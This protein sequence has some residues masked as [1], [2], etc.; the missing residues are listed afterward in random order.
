MSGARDLVRNPARPARDRLRSLL[1]VASVATALLGGC[2]GGGGDNSS[3]ST[4]TPTPAPVVVALPNTL[5]VTI[6]AGPAALA[7]ANEAAANALFATVT[8]CAP[9]STTACRSIDHIQVDTGSTG[10]RIIASA[11]GAAAPA[12]SIDPTTGFAT[13][14]C[15]QFADGYSW[16]T[17]ATADVTLGGRTVASLPVHV[18]G[19]PAAGS[20]PASCASGPSENTVVAFGA[21]GVLGLGNYVQDCGPACATRAVSAFYY[22]CPTSSATSCTPTT[23]SLARQVTNPVALLGTD[24]NGVVVQVPAVPSP[25]AS[26]VTGTILF[27]IGTQADNALGSAR[28]YGLSSQGTFTATFNGTAYPGSFIDSGSNAY[29]FATNAIPVCADASFFFCPVTSSNAPTSVPES[30]LITGTNG[31]SATVTFN[32]DNADTLFRTSFTAFP[33]LGGPNG[34]FS[35]S[36]AGAFDFGLPFFYGR[37]VYVVIEGNS[38]AGVAAPAVAF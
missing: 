35:N 7:A 32:I 9:G 30:A 29:F 10:L 16:G 38:V 6:D 4:P 1:V 27:G 22:V 24:N 34:S 18:I 19:D 31:V 13:R 21:N 20:A 26:N 2:G 15:V 33:G 28:V 23:I 17:V 12:A 37:N 3:S 36:A 8:V 11:L 14:E 25:G 5:A